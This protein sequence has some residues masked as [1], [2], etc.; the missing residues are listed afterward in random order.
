MLRMGIDGSAANEPLQDTRI[1]PGGSRFLQTEAASL[2]LT[3]RA[4]H[5]LLHACIV[6]RADIRIANT[7]QSLPA[8][9]GEDVS[10]TPDGEAHHQQGNQD[11]T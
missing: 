2:L 6:L 8:V 3:H 10:N 7:D 1:E 9:A 5:I 4:Q 11:Q